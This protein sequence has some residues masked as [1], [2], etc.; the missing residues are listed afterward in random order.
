[1]P[2]YFDRG[3]N[4]LVLS[5]IDSFWWFNSQIRIGKLNRTHLKIFS[6]M[7]LDK[8]QSRASCF[9][10]LSWFWRLKKIIQCHAKCA[11]P[12]DRASKRVGLSTAYQYACPRPYWR[13]KP[14]PGQEWGATRDSQGQHY[15]RNILAVKSCYRT[16]RAQEHDEY[17]SLL[18][19]SQSG[20]EW[21][22]MPR[23]IRNVAF[24]FG[25]F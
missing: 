17:H 23:R 24:A 13:W 5:G 19:L 9:V 8:G 14:Y 12:D 16:W 11:I 18:T 15:F 6:C 10:I 25:C 2:F 21:N 1:M 7:D 4:L 20:S 3:V 22:R